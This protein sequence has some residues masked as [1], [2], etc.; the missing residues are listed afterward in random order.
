MKDLNTS[1]APAAIGPYVQAKDIGQLVF[2]SGQLPIDPATGEMPAA[3][4]AQTTQCL[5]NVAAILLEAGLNASN[6]IKTTV[7]VKDLNHFAEVNEAYSRFFEGTGSYP[8]RSCVEV[9]RLPKDAMVE[10]EVIAL[11]A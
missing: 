2:T 3:A 8:A 1:N 10:I 7:F 11:R 6:I 5:A 4:G 9:A